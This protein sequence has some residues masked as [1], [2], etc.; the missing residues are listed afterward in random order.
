MEEGVLRLCCSNPF[1][2]IID[3][4]NVNCLIE[5]D[6]IVGSILSYRI[7]VLYCTWNRRADTYNTRFCG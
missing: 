5:V 3:N 4:Q 7:G 2:D 1:L 6:K